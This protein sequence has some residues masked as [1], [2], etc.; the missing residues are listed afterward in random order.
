MVASAKVLVAIDVFPV[1]AWPTV[2]EIALLPQPAKAVA[3]AIVKI[4]LFVH[5]GL[6]TTG[7]LR[8]GAAAGRRFDPGATLAE[9]SVSSWGRGRLEEVAR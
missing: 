6:G 1:A 7:T 4:Q 8:D 2:G 9:H 5:R 3:D